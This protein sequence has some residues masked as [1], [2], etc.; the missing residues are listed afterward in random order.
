MRKLPEP[1]LRERS[2]EILQNLGAW[3]VSKDHELARRYERLGQTRCQEGVPLH[4]VVRTLQIIKNNMIQWVRDQ[5]IGQSPLEIY[6]EEELE[7]GADR[8]FDTM[9]YYVVRGYEKELRRG[10]SMVA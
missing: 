1:D 7:H 5:G 8:I 4:E 6:A 10:R 2:R 3:L 9:V